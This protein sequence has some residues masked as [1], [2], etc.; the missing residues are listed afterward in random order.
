M[1]GVKEKEKER[2]NKA[3]RLKAGG[4]HRH[5]LKWFLVHVILVCNFGGLYEG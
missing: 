5:D 4:P 2:P 1:C 3:E